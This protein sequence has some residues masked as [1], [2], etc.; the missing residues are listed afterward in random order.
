MRQLRPRKRT[1]S[2]NR[3]AITQIQKTS[4]ISSKYSCLLGTNPTHPGVITM[5]IML[6]CP[7]HFQIHLRLTYRLDWYQTLATKSRPIPHPQFLT[8]Y[9]IAS[10]DLSARSKSLSLMKTSTTRRLYSGQVPN[11]SH[12]CLNSARK[13]LAGQILLVTEANKC[14]TVSHT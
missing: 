6:L 13:G 14:L 12:A 2:D 10:K 9:T 1:L 5:K 3:S 11:T 8:L 7:K 4:R